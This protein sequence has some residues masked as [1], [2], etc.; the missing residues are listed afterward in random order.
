MTKAVSAEYVARNVIRDNTTIV[1]SSFT[2]HPRAIIGALVLEVLAGRKEGL[3]L[4]QLLPLV[5]PGDPNHIDPAIQS[6]MRL[7]TPFASTLSRKLG[8]TSNPHNFLPS[9]LSQVGRAYRTHLKPEVTVI[10]CP[11]PRD[12]FYSMGIEALTR[13]TID[14]NCLIIVEE[15]DQVPFTNGTLIPTSRVEYVVRSNYP[16]LGPAPKE[17]DEE[18]MQIARHL[19]ARVSNRSTLQLGIGAIPDALAKAI[20]L[21]G[22]EYRGVGIDTEV[23]GDELYRL[24]RSGVATGRHKLSYPGQATATGLLGS[25]WMYEQ[26]LQCTAGIQVL[27]A[28]VT[29]N[30]LRFCTNPSFVSVNSGMSVDLVGNVVSHGT[31]ED[32]QLRW[33]SGTGGQLE[34]AKAM[35]YSSDG[36]GH[37][38]IAIRTRASIRHGEQRCEVSCIV[39]T[40]HTRDQVTVPASVA[41]SVVT[42]HGIADLHGLTV[43]ERANA[44][45][46]IADP[47]YRDELRREATRLNLI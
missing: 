41:F 9:E 20:R 27:P 2:A 37:A 24:I 12:G 14:D 43:A 31:D 3:I 45:I 23:M 13:D 42:R 8:T 18:A 28:S 10:Q 4:L 15:N 6:K 17:P 40:H 44:L 35:C 26:L 29:N 16:I 1:A 38:Y 47:K 11:P 21:R 36:L 32:G 39:P 22:D 7:V 46:E 33:V 25:T 5:Y 19:I 34:F 30:P